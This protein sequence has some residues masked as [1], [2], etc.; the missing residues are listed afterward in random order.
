[1]ADAVDLL[2]IGGGI[3]GAGIARDA[4]GRGLSVV[5]CEKGDLAEATSSRSSKLVHGGLRYL[6]YYQFRLVHEAL[7]EREVLLRSAPHVVWPTRF[8]L[9]HS[10]QDRPAWMLRI[11]LF[12]YDHIGGRRTLPGCRALDL[13][14]EPEGAALAPGYVKG[15]EYPDCCADDARLTILA[16]LDARERGA[17]ILTRMLFETARRDGG[18]WRATIVDATSGEKREIA[19]RALV[20]AAGPWV[21]Q[22]IGRV[23]GAKTKFSVKL[24]KGSHI[25]TPKFFDGPQAYLMQNHDRRVIF[26]IPYQGDLALI[27]TTEIP[28]DGA[29]ETVAADEEEIVYLLAAVAGYFRNAPRREDVIEA[30]AGVRPLFDDGHGD[31]SAVTRDYVLE[32]DAADG[33]PLLN[34]FG[35]KITTFRRLAEHALHKLKPFFPTASGDWTARATLPGG[36]IDDGDFER[37]VARLAGEYPFLPPSL[38]LHYARLYGARATKLI[39]AAASLADL[40]RRFGPD[41]YE[42]E[43]LYLV[44]EEWAETADD[45]LVRRTKHGL[46]MSADERAEF[47]SWI[48]SRAGGDA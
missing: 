25:V 30:W 16:A 36:E 19:A 10:P 1:M 15:F 42:R 6:E 34:V 45:I 18:L 29:P 8:V 13:R 43:A 31:P 47:A 3:N 22:V 11:G 12:L 5:L 46:R 14:R 44:A 41:F 32:L 26:V 21:D 27:G 9:P 38:A 4:A 40:G 28:F 37:F 33:A 7:A 39:G 2:V 35:G 17:R 48:E 24:V 20:N 23:D